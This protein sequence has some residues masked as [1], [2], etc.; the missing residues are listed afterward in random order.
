VSKS[1][2]PA[3]GG[4]YSLGVGVG[5]NIADGGD[6]QSDILNTQDIHNV[7]SPDFVT[8]GPGSQVW[9]VGW[10]LRLFAT[11]AKPADPL[12]AFL[13]IAH[14]VGPTPFVFGLGPELLMPVYAEAV[15]YDYQGWARVEWPVV[16]IDFFNNLGTDITLD[17]Q[18]WAKAW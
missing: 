12:R 6:Q 13:R 7:G 10:A 18:F 17:F 1:F 14:G 4:L 3:V 8:L 11:N 9:F 5:A 16:R 15:A 2:T